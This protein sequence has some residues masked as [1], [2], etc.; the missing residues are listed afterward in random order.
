M[1]VFLLYAGGMDQVYFI[2]ARVF[3]F[4][5]GL[6]QRIRIFSTG[7]VISIFDLI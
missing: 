1:G 7:R 4:L 5:I 6:F 2:S 3:D